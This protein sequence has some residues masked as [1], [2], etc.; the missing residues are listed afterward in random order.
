MS[1]ETIDPLEPYGCPSCRNEP[2][3]CEPDLDT[4]SVEELDRAIN[5]IPGRS[6]GPMIPYEN[7]KA[8]V[9]RVSVQ[10]TEALHALTQAYSLVMGR[11]P[12]WS[13]WSKPLGYEE[14]LGEIGDAVNALKH[15]VKPHWI[16]PSNQMPESQPG[17]QL[18]LVMRRGAI[19][20]AII[21]GNS[22]G[23]WLDGRV[24]NDVLAWLPIPM[25]DL[26]K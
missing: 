19:G 14:A 6:L 8:E 13:K 25:F 11:Q 5:I 10:R 22:T 1:T 23:F 7:H 26:T 4:C 16:N 2:C 15:A 24:I 9:L 21:A 12:D 20:P 18:V 17:L 3:R